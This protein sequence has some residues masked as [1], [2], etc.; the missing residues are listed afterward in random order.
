M[1]DFP[2]RQYTHEILKASCMIS[3]Q[4]N[5]SSKEHADVQTL[6]EGNVRADIAQSTAKPGA[7]DMQLGLTQFGGS[8]QMYAQML[9]HFATHVLPH[10]MVT[11][12]TAHERSDIAALQAEAHSLN[13]AAG[14]VGA[15]MLSDLCMRL[16]DACRAAQTG[17]YDAAKAGLEKHLKQIASEFDIL[18][19]WFKDKHFVVEC[20][21]GPPA[22]GSQAARPS[23]RAPALASPRCRAPTSSA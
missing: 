4:S 21:G 20:E 10:G 15:S 19:D 23:P 1:C 7:I 12:R 17:S 9:T 14:F 22:I 3:K 11:L 13:G 8:R 18:Q 5:T 16:T 6:T 2:I